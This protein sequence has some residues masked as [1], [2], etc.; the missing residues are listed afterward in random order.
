L[1]AQLD[2]SGC[3][4]LTQWPEDLHVT[5]W[6]DVADISLETFPQALKD[7]SL[8]WRSV[9]VSQQVVFNPETITAHE[10]LSEQNLELRRVMM[11]RMGYEKFMEQAEPNILDTDQD[12]GGVRKLLHIDVQGDEPLICL[13]VQ[14]PSTG[15][16]YMIRVPP[17]MHTCHQAAAW[18]AGYD[19]PDAYHPLIET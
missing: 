7:A 11:E 16:R 15:R 9:F 3:R 4:S 1:L 18:I 14:C 5:S 19:N 12:P 2:V 6:I 13:A 10:V 17:D 8:R